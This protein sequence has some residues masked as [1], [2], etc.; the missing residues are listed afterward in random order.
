MAAR[1]LPLSSNPNWIAEFNH[2][3]D[4]SL[5]YSRTPWVTLSLS[6]THIHTLIHSIT[7]LLMLFL[8]RNKLWLNQKDWCEWSLEASHPEVHCGWS[9][10]CLDEPFGECA[11][12]LLDCTRTHIHTHIYVYHRHKHAY[13]AS[14]LPHELQKMSSN[15]FLLWLLLLYYYYLLFSLSLV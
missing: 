10:H 13:T 7:H 14:W 6:H 8:A 4:H 11:S 2:S 12:L 1:D 9:S 3:I 15:L 5:T